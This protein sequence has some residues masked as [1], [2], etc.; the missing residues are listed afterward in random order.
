MSSQ[1][2]EFLSQVN[3][4][5]NG[6]LLKIDIPQYVDKL[7]KNATIISID[8]N[9]QLIAFIAYYDNDPD[10]EL[11]FL[12]M[13][14]VESGSKKMGYGN[15]LLQ[16]SI[17]EIEKKGFKR[18]GLEVIKDNF[19]AI[20]LYEKHGFLFSGERENNFIYMEKKITNDR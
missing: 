7:K 1:L 8:K 14:A 13:L 6:E 19:K 17:K 20:Q 10:C 16:I 3:M 18:Y 9:G 2:K 12:S 15:T 11:A 4:E 5:A